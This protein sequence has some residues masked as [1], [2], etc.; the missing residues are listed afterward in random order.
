[1]PQVIAK[2]LSI[3]RE[4]K[5]IGILQAKKDG[6][7]PTHVARHIIK[8]CMTMLGPPHS[9][10]SGDA[11][12]KWQLMKVSR[13]MMPL[14]HQCMRLRGWKKA[15]I[16]MPLKRLA[17]RL[18]ATNLDVDTFSDGNDE[19]FNPKNKLTRFVGVVLVIGQPKGNSSLSPNLLHECGFI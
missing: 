3:V 8:P 9:I 19:W 16:T 5:S 2:R 15:R 4:L 17:K 11:M 7:A 14:I 6:R 13:A 12:L 1:M 10:I 18:H